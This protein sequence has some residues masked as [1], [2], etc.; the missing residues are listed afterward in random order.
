M[1]NAAF[2][3]LQYWFKA[4]AK[5]GE[6]IGELR[7]DPKK[8]LISFYITLLF[9]FL[10]AMTALLG[11][12]LHTGIRVDPWVPIPDIRGKPSFVPHRETRP[13]PVQLR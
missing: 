4:Y 10:Y 9:A 3:S 12:L 13:V 2:R 8:L 7:T 1:S 11:Y 5:P 6:T